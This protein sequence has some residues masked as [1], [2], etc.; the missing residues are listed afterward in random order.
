MRLLYALALLLF[1]C[2]SKPPAPE[3][4]ILPCYKAKT[5]KEFAA[6]DRQRA[7][8]PNAPLVVAGKQYACVQPI[9]AVESNCFL[10]KSKKEFAKLGKLQEKT[11]AWPIKVGTKY[12]RCIQK[13]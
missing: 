8:K 11:P 10:T 12:Y 6:L 5:F 13:Q 2:S 4:E 9:M 7:L 3:P 1:S